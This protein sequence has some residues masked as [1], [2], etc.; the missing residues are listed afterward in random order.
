[1][2]NKSKDEHLSVRNH[3]KRLLGCLFR[4]GDE[5]MEVDSQR[6]FHTPVDTVS[7][8]PYEPSFV[9]RN[10]AGRFGYQFW[11]GSVL[12]T[13]IRHEILDLP[14]GFNRRDLFEAQMLEAALT[15][16]EFQGDLSEIM[17]SIEPRLPPRPPSPKTL[18]DRELI[19]QQDLEYEETKRRDQEKK[20][21][22]V[23][24]A[25]QEREASVLE[26]ARKRQEEESLQRLIRRKK[27]VV[28]AEPD[29]NHP[30]AIVVQFRLP[31]GTRFRRRFLKTD[32]VCL[33]FDFVDVEINA[34][35][36][37]LPQ[38]RFLFH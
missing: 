13:G 18:A 21:E 24:K 28:S 15:G 37:V 11:K 17:P 29:E 36:T 31:D 22:A 7:P 12:G 35:E 38:K 34:S 9:P 26:E 20:R 27:K 2:R 30:E 14:E 16:A 33:L 10:I 19:R 23:A 8:E 1:M 6:S 5:D 3:S 25:R 4:D 32:P